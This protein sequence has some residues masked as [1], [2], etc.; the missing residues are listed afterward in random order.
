V[1]TASSFLELAQT[2]LRVAGE[3]RWEF[4]PFTPER[5]AQDPGDFYS[6][7]TKARRLLGWGPATSLEEGL[8]RTVEFYRAHRDHYW[9]RPAR[10]AA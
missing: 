5:K 6:D 10:Q 1:D 7:I 4:A 3:G 8:R 2:I 9:T